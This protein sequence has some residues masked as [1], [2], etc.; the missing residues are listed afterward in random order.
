MNTDYPH[1]DAADAIIGSE[2]AALN[3]LQ[4]GFHEMPN[5]EFRSADI[6]TQKSLF[7]RFS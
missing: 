5:E 6:S 7:H 2:F 4:H 3:A 1:K